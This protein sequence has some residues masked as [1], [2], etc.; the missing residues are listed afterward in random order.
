MAHHCSGH[1]LGRPCCLPVLFHLFPESDYRRALPSRPWH[2][3]DTATP[4]PYAR[5]AVPARRADGSDHW[6]PADIHLGAR[7]SPRCMVLLSCSVGVEIFSGL[8][9]IA[10]PD[11]RACTK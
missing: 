10:G 2:S 7:L 1:S 5:L 3:C 11:A 6:E 9:R 4:A 8:S